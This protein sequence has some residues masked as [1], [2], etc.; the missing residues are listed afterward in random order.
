MRR[1]DELV[2]AVGAQ[3]QFGAVDA[4]SDGHGQAKT[5]EWCH[6]I[7]EVRAARASPGATKRPGFGRPLDVRH[8]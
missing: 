3:A 2:A 1:D 4:M 8:S 7:L 6:V 5:F